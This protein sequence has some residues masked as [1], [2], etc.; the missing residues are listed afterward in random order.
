L[1]DFLR[2][3]GVFE[4]TGGKFLITARQVL[5]RNLLQTLHIFRDRALRSDRMQ[6]LDITPACEKLGTT[7]TNIA[8]IKAALRKVF[9]FCLDL[10]TSTCVY[11]RQPECRLPD[12]KYD[13][14][15]RGF[16]FTP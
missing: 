10:F 7:G 13:A 15:L 12:C 1:P 16:Q 2:F 5:V 3:V 8:A 6:A 11:S 4:K 14:D 9:M